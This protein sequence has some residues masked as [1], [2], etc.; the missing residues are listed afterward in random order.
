MVQGRDD[1]VLCP[2]AAP[3][4]MSIPPWSWKRHPLLM[5]TRSPNRVFLPKSVVNGGNIRKDFGNLP[6]G[7]CTLNSTTSSGVV[8]AVDLGREA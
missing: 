6:A 4:P 8:R 7:Q 5:K 1:L 2:I 3:P